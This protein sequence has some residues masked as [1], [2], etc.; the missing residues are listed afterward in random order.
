MM[1]GMSWFCWSIDVSDEVNHLMLMIT[2]LL[3]FGLNHTDDQVILDTSE[4]ENQL[5]LSTDR[6]RQ[7]IDTDNSWISSSVAVCVQSFAPD[8]SLFDTCLKTK[9]TDSVSILILKS[10]QR[11]VRWRSTSQFYP[12]ELQPEQKCSQQFLYIHCFTDIYVQV[13]GLNWLLMH[14]LRFT[15]LYTIMKR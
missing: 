6:D 13:F 11:S 3:M 7:W 8:H 4:A 9:I 5:I 1:L 2:H 14:K 12:K 10:K 15:S